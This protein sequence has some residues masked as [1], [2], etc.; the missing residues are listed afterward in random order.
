MKATLIV[1]LLCL[2]VPCLAQYDRYPTPFE[3]KIVDSIHNRSK[4]QLFSWAS[5]WLAET[6]KSSK[7]I[8]QMSDREAGKIVGK[9]KMVVPVRPMGMGNVAYVDYTITIDV[10][11]GR[12]R[13]RLT[14]FYNGSSTYK[15][16]VWGGDFNNEK[17]DHGG[18]TGMSRKTW[19]NLKED[20][21]QRVETLIYSLQHYM[22]KQA[23][24]KDDW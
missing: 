5:A 14:D 8:V 15:D 13:C 18:F 6:F 7:A 20:V 21:N 2:A 10:K 22:K 11:E 1:L 12:Y 17:P 24:G 9:A 4:D 3:Y 19:E 16:K 23:E